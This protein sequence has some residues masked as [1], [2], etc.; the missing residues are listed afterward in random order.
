MKHNRTQS[1][2][3]R[4]KSKLQ[5]EALETRDLLACVLDTGAAYDAVSGILTI[6][7]TNG[8]DNISVGVVSTDPDTI[9]GSGDETSDLTVTVNGDAVATCSLLDAAAPVNGLL[10]NGGNG[11]DVITVDDAVLLGVEAN[12]GNGH[13]SIDGGGGN[14]TLSGGNGKDSIDGAAGDDDLSGGNG[15]DYLQGGLGV[16]DVSGDNGPDELEDP[17]GDTGLNGGNGP[18]LINGVLEPKRGKGHGKKP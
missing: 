5:V 6:T 3:A 13:D 8:G 7:G 14:D 18:D 10:I 9:P 15:A 2:S 12:G 1:R 4:E 17:D 11:H 16:D